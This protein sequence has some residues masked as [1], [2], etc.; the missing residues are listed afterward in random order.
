MLAKSVARRIVAQPH[1]APLWEQADSLPSRITLAPAKVLPGHPETVLW[2]NQSI[3][4]KPQGEARSGYAT[5]TPSACAHFVLNST[6]FQPVV[7]Y[8][9]KGVT[10]FVTRRGW[11]GKEGTGMNRLNGTLQDLGIAN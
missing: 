1:R 10:S 2:V 8:L 6:S 9:I 7:L 3:F 4:R 11:K 5:L